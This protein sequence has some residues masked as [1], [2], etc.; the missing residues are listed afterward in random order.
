[1]NGGRLLSSLSQAPGLRSPG[2]CGKL[3]IIGGG[4]M[5]EAIVKAVLKKGQPCGSIFVSDPNAER[6]KYLAEKYKITCTSNSM[7]VA[8]KSDVVL[9]GVKPQN[10]TTVVA[11]LKNLKWTHDQV[12]ISILA[13]VN[14]GTLKDGF[15]HC[16]HII[17]TMPNTPASI[18]E[19]MTVWTYAQQRK[20]KEEESDDRSSNNSSSISIS[21]SIISG[22]SVGG[23]KDQAKERGEDMAREY[24]RKLLSSMG[25]ELEVSTESYLDMAT[26]IS[27]SGPAYIYLMTESMI[28]AAVHL[29]FPRTIAHKLV[30][31]TIRGSSSLTLLPENQSLHD[32]RYMVTSPGGTTASALYELERGGFRTVVSDAVWAAYRRSLELGENNPNIGPG[33]NKF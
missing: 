5:A 16:S 28:D 14:M 22:T 27:G 1:M 32:L 21:S 25:V 24:A 9:L 17:R 13:G 2:I 30:T 19:G 6:R 10:L 20:P 18:Q 4:M 7:K 8:D 31:Q 33:R 26:A 29:G 12:L 15:P 11:D 23:D 3:G